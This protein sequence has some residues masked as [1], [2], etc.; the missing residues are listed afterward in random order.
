MFLA[1]RQREVGTHMFITTVV[2][3]LAKNPFRL[4][5]MDARG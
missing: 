1:P 3:D 2:I 5:G 4:H